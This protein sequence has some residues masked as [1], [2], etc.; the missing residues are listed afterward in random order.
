[1]TTTRTNMVNYDEQFAGAHYE[2][3]M[4]N[5][6]VF[7]AASNGALVMVNAFKQ[8]DFDRES[9]FKNFTGLSR[10]D[11]TSIADA[12][13]ATLG[14]EEDIAVKLKRKFLAD[15]TRDAFRTMG[16]SME[17]YAQIMGEQMGDETRQEALERVIAALDAAMQNE[18]DTI[19]LDVS[20]DGQNGKMS[21]VH[22]NN[23]M[24]KLG[25][26]SSN[27]I[28]LVMCGAAF[29]DW[30]G[31]MLGGVAPQFNDS[32]ISVYNG[33]VPTLGRP[34]IVTDSPTLSAN[35]K[36]TILGLQRGAGV[37][38]IS[39][40]TDVV[41]DDITG[42]EN[43]IKRCQAEGAYNLKLRGYKWNT[44]GG[45]NNPT[46]G[47]VATAS[48]WTRNATSH[49]DLPGFRLVVSQ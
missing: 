43:L 46:S 12:V 21:H 49:K 28:A 24:K 23:A 20:G 4:Q 45:G 31:G 17:L 27:V 34:V 16:Y 37:V 26:K 36:Y 41:F 14:Q 25:D 47:T 1:M 32:G 30:A 22:V 3:I 48:N 42:K 7:N 18:G 15:T 33:G 40:Q 5:T 6:N 8:G 2:R 35:G 44:V 19:N 38:N 10:R 39:E 11:A 13:A 29:H 9:F